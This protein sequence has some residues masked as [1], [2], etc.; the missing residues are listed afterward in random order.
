MPLDSWLSKYWVCYTLYQYFK[1]LVYFPESAISGIPLSLSPDR[2]FVQQTVALPA[3]LTSK[4][5]KVQVHT[6][7]EGEGGRAYMAQKTAQPRL[8]DTFRLQAVTGLTS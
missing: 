5:S 1:I 4:T 3:H 8:L 7:R 6:G 2:K